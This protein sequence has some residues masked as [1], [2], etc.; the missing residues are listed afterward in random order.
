MIA[1]FVSGVLSVISFYISYRQHKEKGVI[2]TNTWLWATKEQKEKMDERV[3][4]AEYR[5]ARNVFFMIGVIFFLLA[6]EVLT[7]IVWFQYLI[8]MLTAFLLVYAIVQ[9]VK[10]VEDK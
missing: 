5:L 10:D 4:K 8:Y 3:K 7:L 2:F 1:A 9:S 6:L